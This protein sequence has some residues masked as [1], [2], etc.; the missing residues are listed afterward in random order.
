ML[1]LNVMALFL[2]LI[3]KRMLFEHVKLVLQNREYNE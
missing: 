1:L 2:Q 3:G